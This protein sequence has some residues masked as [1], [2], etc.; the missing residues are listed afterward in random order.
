MKKKVLAVLLSSILALSCIACGGNNTTSESTASKT[1]ES[2]AT[3]ESTATTTENTEPKEVVT[4]KMLSGEGAKKTALEKIVGNYNDGQG[5]EKGIYVEL[6]VNTD[7][8]KVIEIAQQ[9]GSLPEICRPSTAQMKQFA[10]SGDIIPIEDFPGGTEFLAEENSPEIYNNNQY[11]GKLYCTISEIQPGALVINKDL[12]VAAGIVDENG[13][14]KAPTTWEEVREYAKILTNPAE[15]VYG[16]AYSLKTFGGS[17]LE[18]PFKSSIKPKEEYINYNDLTVGTRG[19]EDVFQLMI[20][21]NKDGSMFP[22]ADTLDNDTLR[23]YF[24]EGKIAMFPSVAWDVGVFSTQFLAKCD[25]EAVQAP[26]QDGTK[27]YPNYS[28]YSGGYCLTKTA[29]EHPEEVFDFY[30]YYFSDEAQSILAEEAGVILLDTELYNTLNVDEH[31]KQYAALYDEEWADIYNLDRKHPS[32]TIEGDTEA[33]LYMK[34][35]AGEITAKEAAEKYAEQTQ[36]ALRKAV[37]E[38]TID[39]SEFVSK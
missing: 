36:A 2:T 5:K 39:I 23:A 34:A 37:S 35:W 26:T 20:D 27:I 6:E 21:I 24:A 14:A 17:F 12:F 33:D 18:Q 8:K 28:A 29:L 31:A 16:F 30:K 15:N 25:W 11:D 9:N 38:G 19:L 22:G 13:E 3:S 4:I 7:Y 10:K 1:T 32:Y